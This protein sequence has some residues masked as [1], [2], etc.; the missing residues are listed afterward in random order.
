VILSRLN[1]EE[2]FIQ[3]AP[4]EWSLRLRLQHF[5]RVLRA[6]AAMAAPTKI[7]SQKQASPAV[8]K[9][10]AASFA[11]PRSARPTRSLPETH[12]SGRAA[13]ASA[14]RPFAV[15]AAASSPAAMS[16][17]VARRTSRRR[18]LGHPSSGA[19]TTRASRSSPRNRFRPGAGSRDVGGGQKACANN[20]Q[21]V[22]IRLSAR[23]TNF[24]NR[25]NCFHLN[26]V[27]KSFRSLASFYVE[28]TSFFPVD[29]ELGDP[30]A[31]R[32]LWQPD[33][34]VLLWV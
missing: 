17:L 22:E 23:G 4:R 21:L 20:W 29:W 19:R 31:S 26:G 25:G 5:R 1:S 7:S 11:P 3:A 27:G 6:P 32:K 8:A 14:F 15:T 34:E 18:A 28:L 10:S 30:W 33:C 24:V 13:A 9:A 16:A 2:R 12:R